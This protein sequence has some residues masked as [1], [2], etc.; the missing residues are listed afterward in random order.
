[1]PS[2]LKISLGILVII[3]AYISAAAA[4]ETQGDMPKKSS[5]GAPRKAVDGTQHRYF[6]IPKEIQLTTEQTA[7]LDEIKQKLAP[8]IVELTGKQHGLLSKEQK[9]ARDDAIAKAKLEGLKGK[10]RT[11]AIN[12]ATNL[13]EDQKKQLTDIK[14]EFARLRTDIKQQIYNLLTAEQRTHFKA[15]KSNK[16]V[17]M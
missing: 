3:A 10:A 17:A 2:L 7:T 13:S 11:A 16:S 14:T 15:P 8:K 9:A 6:A 5:D 4:A 1:M 12:E